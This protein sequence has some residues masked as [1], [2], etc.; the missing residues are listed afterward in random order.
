MAYGLEFLTWCHM[1]LSIDDH[2]DELRRVRAEQAR[3]GRPT[4]RRR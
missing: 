1:A 4:M 2:L 3:R